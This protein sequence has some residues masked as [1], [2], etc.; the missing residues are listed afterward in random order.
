MQTGEPEKY[1]E[2]NNG[3][4][5]MVRNEWADW[6]QSRIDTLEARLKKVEM[7]AKQGMDAPVSEWSRGHFKYIH[8]IATRKD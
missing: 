4:W 3:K 5:S 1:I 6:A 2:M 8:S 7:A